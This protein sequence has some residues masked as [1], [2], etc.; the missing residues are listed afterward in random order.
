MLES[1]LADHDSSLVKEIKAILLLV[2]Q[3]LIITFHAIRN[4]LPFWS[5]IIVNSLGYAIK[6]GLGL[7]DSHP[8]N[9]KHLIESRNHSFLSAG[10]AKYQ[11][12][13]RF[14]LKR[15]I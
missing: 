8:Q 11:K 9:A 7:G 3:Y 6:T 2:Y 10:K 5:S 1:V 14:E 13:K 4:D 12:T 15:S